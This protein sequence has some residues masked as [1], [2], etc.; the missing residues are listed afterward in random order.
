[1]L[2]ETALEATRHNP[3]EEG[4]ADVAGS[5]RPC[6]RR[7]ILNWLYIARTRLQDLSDD[8]GMD[9]YNQRQ[10][11]RWV[12]AAGHRAMAGQRSHLGQGAGQPVRRASFA[13]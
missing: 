13:D 7:R 6:K 4:E 5:P 11:Y 3:E 9:G 10:I 8:E 1:M 2:V 12:P